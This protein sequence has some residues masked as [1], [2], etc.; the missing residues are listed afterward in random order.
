LLLFPDNSLQKFKYFP[1]FSRVTGKN[2]GD[3]SAP[4][5]THRHQVGVVALATAL[6]FGAI[7]SA[8]LV[9]FVVPLLYRRIRD[10]A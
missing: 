2:I 3:A 8:L 6:I 10:R 5:C 9:V 1:V 7:S 4:D